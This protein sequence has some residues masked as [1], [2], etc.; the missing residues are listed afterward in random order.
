M[1]KATAAGHASSRRLRRFSTGTIRSSFAFAVLAFVGAGATHFAKPLRAQTI[2][3]AH[4]GYFVYVGTYTSA[5]DPAKPTGSKGIYAYRFDSSSGE[6]ESLGLAA[7]S[8]QPSFLAADPAGKFLYA[9]NETDIYQ[10]Q[11]SGGVSA[12]SIDRSSGMLSLLN[13]LPSRGGAPAHIATDRTGK[14]V[15][16]SNYDGGS[17]AVFPILPDGRLGAASDFVQHHGSSINKDRQAG[18]HVHETIVS[19]DNRFALSTD[20]GLDDLFVY[21]FD[22][23]TGTLGPQPRVLNLTPGF[24]PRHIAFA[25]NGHFVY[26]ISELGS[27]VSVLPYDPDTGAIS[28]RQIVRLAP[29]DDDPAKKWA[30]EVAV[31]PSGK[32]LYASNR[33]DDFIAVF[34]I[35]PDTGMLKRTETVPLDGKTPRNFAID[36]DGHWLWDANQDSDKITLFRIDQNNGNLMPSGLTLKVGAPSCVLFVPVS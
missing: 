3:A 4:T 16:V 24:G 17:I 36:P 33:G 10:G 20:L 13:E 28:N 26:L 35:D 12:F 7:E 9:V 8:E 31:G 19:P 21:P 22:A 25:P 32:Y 27:T 15:L 2:S 11:P 23:K 14:Y 30:A 1:R 6:V 18:P 29:A 5:G 34:S